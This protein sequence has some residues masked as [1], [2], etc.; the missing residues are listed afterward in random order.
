MSTNSSKTPPPLPTSS[1]TP[2]P[3]TTQSKTPPPLNTPSKTLPPLPTQ[4]KTPTQLP[5]N[6][7]RRHLWGILSG[8]AVVATIVLVLFFFLGR[9]KEFQFEGEYPP[10]VTVELENDE[11]RPYTIEAI[12]GQVCVWFK[13][14]VSYREAKREIKNAG[15]KIVAQIP[16]IGYYLVQLPEDEVKSFLLKINQAPDIEWAFPNMISHPC[17][18]H[19]YLLDNF[20]ADTSNKRDTTSHGRVVTEA[21]TRCGTTSPLQPYNIGVPDGNGICIKKRKN[22]TCTN[23]AVFAV[24]DIASLPHDN[25]IIINMSFGPSLPERKDTDIYYWV[26]ATDKERMDY[27]E[28]Y[29][30]SIRDIIHV[31]KPLKN[32]D[33]IITKA[34]GN[35]GVKVFD[36]AIISY[37]RSKLE[38]DEL[39]ILD[40]HILLVTAG[41]KEEINQDYSNEMEAGHY[42]PW[43]TKVDISD[44]CYGYKRR[45]TSFAAPR[46]A[47]FISSAINETGLSAT[48]VLQLA[49]EV[50]KHDGSLTKEALIQ[51]AKEWKMKNPTADNHYNEFGCLKYR[52]IRKSISD[53]EI[54]ELYNTCDE[55]I[56]VT[57]FLLNAIVPRSEANTL[58]FELTLQPNET[59]YVNGFTDN[60]CFITDVEKVDNP[61]SPPNNRGK[62]D[63]YQIISYNEHLFDS[64]ASGYMTLSNGDRILFKY[65]YDYG[66]IAI[67][68][69]VFYMEDTDIRK[70]YK[71]AG[72][73][74]MNDEQF[75]PGS[76]DDFEEQ[77]NMHIC[78]GGFH[79]MERDQLIILFKN[80]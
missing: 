41:E 22:S 3:L 43:V 25:P 38:P 42:S 37:L 8:L 56:R 64:G 2:P 54:L 26:A 76:D 17:E 57:G 10:I 77:I 59:E 9:S 18:A 28:Q 14:N 20:Y 34:A 45:G 12:E 62:I 21:L 67:Y 27:K 23:N 30:K 4:S 66:F 29:L 58:D 47:C 40:K 73:E 1:K 69:I 15:G 75:Y 70:K 35:E 16:D 7:K 61:T 74:N 53:D 44:F 60:K 13:D 50:T 55:A 36:A 11:G 19:N 33:F 51:A 6:R 78:M 48:K 65:V 68:S 80:K 46:A 5:R 24:K 32:T 63:F 39:E 52:L 49:K 71:I 31:V 79:E 72:V